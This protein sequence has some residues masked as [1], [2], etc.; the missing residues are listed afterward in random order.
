M[1]G[2]TNYSVFVKAVRPGNENITVEVR[3]SDGSRKRVP[4][5]FPIS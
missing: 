2:T 4:F 3:L 1:L 5:T